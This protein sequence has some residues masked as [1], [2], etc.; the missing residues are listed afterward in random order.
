MRTTTIKAARRGSR[1]NDLRAILEG[2]RA[3]IVR[4][5]QDKIRAVRTDGAGRRDVLDDVEGSEADSQDDIEFALMQLKTE[6][7]SK[8][9]TALRRLEVGHYGDCTEC[10]AEIAE[11]RLRALPFAVRCR[12]CE[13]DRETAVERGRFTGHRRGSPSLL[14]DLGRNE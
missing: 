14:L 13:E 3:E 9:D 4:E 1:L 10:G 6:T 2:R 5:L 11:A 7:L 12:D 8:I